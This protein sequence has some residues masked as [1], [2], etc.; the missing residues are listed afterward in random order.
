MP[1]SVQLLSPPLFVA[2]L[3]TVAHVAPHGQIFRR[4]GP[5]ILQRQNMVH[6]RR[7]PRDDALTIGASVRVAH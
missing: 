7:Y 1:V 2:D 3:S 6:L 5:A 4:I